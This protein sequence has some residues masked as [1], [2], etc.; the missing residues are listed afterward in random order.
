MKVL[1]T[2]PHLSSSYLSGISYDLSLINLLRGGGRDV[3]LALLWSC[4]KNWRCSQQKGA[5]SREISLHHYEFRRECLVAPAKVGERGQWNQYVVISYIQIFVVV[6]LL[7]CV[8]LSVAPW[9][10][11]HQSPLFCTVSWSWLKFMC[12]ES[13]M[14]SHH[15]ILC[16]PLLLLPSVFPSIRVFSNELALCIRWPKCWSSSFRISPSNEY[17][18]LISFM[19]D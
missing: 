11:A 3:L 9:T 1:R 8:W 15:L 7:A 12:I 13:A 2:T 10:V 16:H 6:Q 18:V 17:S 5:L 19:V 4:W 14:L